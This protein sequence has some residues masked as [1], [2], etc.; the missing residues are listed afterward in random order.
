MKKVALCF[1]LAVAI[2][3]PAIPSSKA[4]A[5][6]RADQSSGGMLQSDNWAGWI[7]ESSSP[8]FT[9]V[10]SFWKVPQA[11]DRSLGGERRALDWVGIDGWKPWHNDEHIIQVGTGVLSNPFRPLRYYAWYEMSTSSSDSEKDLVQLKG[12]EMTVRP[13]NM[14]EAAIEKESGNRWELVIVNLT[15]KQT[16]SRVVNF[17]TPELTVEVIHENPG[18]SPGD[19]EKTNPVEFISTTFNHYPIYLTRSL[20]RLFPG[21]TLLPVR[22]K[23]NGVFVATPSVLAGACF[24]VADESSP[25]SAPPFCNA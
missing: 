14:I 15:T 12:K 6:S 1:C 24:N 2:L 19:F 20:P 4:S 17:K 9:E 3:L 21:V 7:A 11:T 10:E 13:G 5:T 22:I 23:E 25:P 8:L 18:K 16:W